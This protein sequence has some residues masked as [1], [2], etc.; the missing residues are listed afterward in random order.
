[1]QTKITA[2]REHE[3]QELYWFTLLQELHSVSLP[4]SKEIHL[5]TLSSSN[6]TTNTFAPYKKPQHTI[7]NTTLNP[8]EK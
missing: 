2:K 8:I 4:T 6:T 3:Y 1:M 5:R 7:E